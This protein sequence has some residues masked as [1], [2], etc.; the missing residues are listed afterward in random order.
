MEKEIWRTAQ[1]I[2]PDGSIE[3]FDSYE[4]SNLGRV[5]SYKRGKEKILKSGTISKFGHQI[6]M[7]CKNNKSYGRNI[8]RLVLSTF[9]PEDWFENA[10][11]DH[12]DSNPKNNRIDNLRWTTYKEN[13]STDHARR[14]HS[15][16]QK[17]KKHSEET[18]KK[19]SEAK[20]GKPSSM[21][22]KHHSEESKRKMSE[23]KKGK[24][25][26]SKHPQAKPCVYDNKIFGSYV[27]AYEYAKA[28]GY[29]KK[30]LAFKKMI[31][32]EQYSS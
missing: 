23:A 28:N 32:K 20:K 15:E 2:N 7:L 22:S 21:L 1:Y 3:T 29:T 14:A 12:I 16:A 11:V 19:M 8:H 27:E 10:I 9:N 25:N 4:V 13:N 18:R 31:K 24:F 17:G 30:Y 5:K 26:G 6:V